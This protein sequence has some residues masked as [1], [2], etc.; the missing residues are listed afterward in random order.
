MGYGKHTY[1]NFGLI[2]NK[3]WSLLV[4]SRYQYELM[5]IP[6]SNNIEGCRLFRFNDVDMFGDVVKCIFS[7]NNDEIMNYG[8]CYGYDSLK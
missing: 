1:H 2:S 5:C 7:M 3:D 8:Y 6:N 4:K